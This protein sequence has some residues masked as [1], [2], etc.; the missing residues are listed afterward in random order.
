MEYDKKDELA[1]LVADQMGSNSGI[2]A[3][4]ITRAF[5]NEILAKSGN[6]IEDLESKLIKEKNPKPFNCELNLMATS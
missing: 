1:K 2:P 5:A 4:H 6:T 3:F